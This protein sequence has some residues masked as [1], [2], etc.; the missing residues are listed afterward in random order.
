MNKKSIIIIIA[1]VAILLILGVIAFAIFGNTGASNNTTNEVKNSIIKP[2]IVDKN[3]IK[4][5]IIG[6]EGLL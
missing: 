4:G 6:T 5:N 1:I 3:E 2:I